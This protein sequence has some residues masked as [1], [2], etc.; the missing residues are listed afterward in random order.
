MRYFAGIFTW[1]AILF[2]FASLA[3]LVVYTNE[4]STL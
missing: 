3:L 2:Y 1:I 4:Q